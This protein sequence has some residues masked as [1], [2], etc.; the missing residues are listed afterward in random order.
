M[1]VKE[2]LVVE[3]EMNS[4]FADDLINNLMNR[5]WGGIWWSDYR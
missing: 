2:G 4:K 5:C 1:V 3:E